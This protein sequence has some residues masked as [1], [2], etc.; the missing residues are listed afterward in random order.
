M[1]NPIQVLPIILAQHFSTQSLLRQPEPSAIMVDGDSVEQFNE[2]LGS[3]LVIAYA[4]ALELIHRA[5]RTEGGT[6]IDLCCGPGHF[7]LFLA[8]Y[9]GY[10]RVVGVD[11]SEPMI[12]AARKNAELWGLSDRV[13]FEVG[14]ALSARPDQV[15]K[16]DLVTCNDAAHHL[17]NLNAVS[18]LFSNMEKLC[19]GS[20][21]VLMMDLVRLRTEELTTRYTK[22]IGKGYKERFYQDFCDSMRAAWTPEEIST[23]IPQQSSRKWTQIVQKLLPTIQ[24]AVGYPND[25]KRLR[26]RGGLPWSNNN[27]PVPMQMRSDWNLFRALL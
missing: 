6:A 22:V 3:K 27:H 26:V 12:A 17:P 23:T 15:G 13:H 19:G 24:I 18:A 8:K 14:D 1:T 21:L 10:E 2:V 4:G 16:Y 5:R 25:G 11:L 7:T 9:L 20:G